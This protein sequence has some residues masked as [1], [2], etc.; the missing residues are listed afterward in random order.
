V[1]YSKEAKDA[2]LS[3]T[4]EDVFIK[5]HFWDSKEINL[6]T[7]KLNKKFEEGMDA[8]NHQKT[9]LFDISNDFELLKI[10]DQDALTHGIS[11]LRDSYLEASRDVLNLLKVLENEGVDKINEKDE[12]VLDLSISLE[13]V[14]EVQ[15]D[16]E[17]EQ[18][19]NQSKP[20]FKQPEVFWNYKPNQAFTIKE[21]SSNGSF[22]L[23]NNTLSHQNSTIIS[24]EWI[25]KIQKIVSEIKY[26]NEVLDDIELECFRK[27]QSNFMNPK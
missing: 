21:S 4:P 2:E 19:Y 5:D 9:T 8:S 11:K 10:S 25:T 7:N 12:E 26:V 6:S 27:G 1:S 24:E 3:L 20:S 18:N 16:Q 23:K 13:I 17:I 15:P 22:A 14:K